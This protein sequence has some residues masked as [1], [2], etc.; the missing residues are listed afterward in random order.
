MAIT[1]TQEPTQYWPV[2]NDVEWVFT[3]TNTGQANFSFVVEFYLNGFIHSTHEVYPESGNAGKFGITTIGRSIS[4]SNVPNQVNLSAETNAIN[5]FSILIYEKYGTPPTIYIATS[6]SSSGI[7]FLNG[8]LRYEEILLNWTPVKYDINF[9][10]RGELFLTEFPRNRK[11]LVRYDESKFLSIINSG[12]GNA[13][14]EVKLYTITNSL[15]ATATFN[16]TLGLTVPM[17]SVGPSRLEAST[18]LTAANFVNC[19]YY[20]VRIYQ[21]STPTKTSEA[22]KLYYDQSCT[23]YEPQRLLWLNRY[24]AWESFTFT[25]LSEESTDTEINRYSKSTG[26]WNGTVYGNTL[27]SGEQMVMSKRSTDRLILNTDWIH[28][29]VQQWL[30]RELYESPRVYLHLNYDI[31]LLTPVIITNTQTVLKQRK[32][33]GLIQEQITIEKSYTKVSQLG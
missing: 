23:R 14:V 8:S 3:S 24:G 31:N 28:Q 18:S 26:V 13:T 15:I 21:T 20:T 29:D 7:R 16:A 4:T 33:A 19:Y 32:K 1:I 5:T 17:L 22:Y 2:C 9:W 30:V 6:T 12:G 10:P 27:A 11:E 25:L